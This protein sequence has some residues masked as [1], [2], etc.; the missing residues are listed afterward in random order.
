MFGFFIKRRKKHSHS[1]V[2][3][4][5]RIF[6]LRIFGTVLYVLEE[7]LFLTTQ[8]QYLL[9]LEPVK[10]F[11]SVEKNANYRDNI[12]MIL[13]IY[14]LKDFKDL[15]NN[16]T[17]SY[18]FILSTGSFFRLHDLGTCYETDSFIAFVT[19]PIITKIPMTPS[20]RLPIRSKTPGVKSKSDHTTINNFTSDFCHNLDFH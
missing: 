16:Y 4:V 2:A 13:E 6:Q 12:T 1:F 10:F 3:Q 20:A 11:F 14:K 8:D 19:M 15:R 7:H 17:Q 5:F 9:F 18:L